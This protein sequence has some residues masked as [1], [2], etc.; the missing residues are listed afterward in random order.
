MGYLQSCLKIYEK[1][2]YEKNLYESGKIV[3]GFLIITGISSYGSKYL[4][5]CN[6][7]LYNCWLWIWQSFKWK[8]GDGLIRLRIYLPVIYIYLKTFCIWTICKLFSKHVF[9]C[10]TQVAVLIRDASLFEN[11]KWQL[12]STQMCLLV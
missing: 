5:V 1:N 12:T 4:F 9:F 7:I 2:L 6:A 3:W 10:T 8:N 11:L